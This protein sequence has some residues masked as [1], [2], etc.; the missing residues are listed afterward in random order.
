[1]SLAW[2]MLGSGSTS[3]ISAQW[4]ANDKSTAMFAEQF[5]KNYREGKSA[6]KALQTASIAMIR[7]KSIGSHEPYY[8]AAFT[9]LGDFR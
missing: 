2:A 1:M 9:L 4:E 5:Y 8:W 3:V 6:A 7:N